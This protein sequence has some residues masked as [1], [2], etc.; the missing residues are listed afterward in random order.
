M[1]IGT[2]LSLVYSQL[3]ILLKVKYILCSVVQK[4]NPFNTPE[5][6][7]DQHHQH[8]QWGECARK[9]KEREREGEKNF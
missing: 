5:S 8:Q 9:E 1:R 2:K 3:N 6:Y 7:Y 4:K